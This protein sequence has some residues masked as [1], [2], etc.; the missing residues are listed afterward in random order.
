[1]SY[2]TA[3]QTGTAAPFG[4]VSPA[5]LELQH[6]QQGGQIGHAPPTYGQDGGNGHPG[7]LAEKIQYPGAGQEYVSQPQPTLQPGAPQ[8]YPPQQQQQGQMYQS[9]T[10]LAS[11]QQGPTPV[12]CPSCG[13]R[14]LTRTEFVSGGTTHLAALLFCCVTC[15]GCIPYMA[16]WFKDVEH[17]CGNCGTLLAVWHKSGRT[18]VMAHG[19]AGAGAG[20]K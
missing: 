9:A 16:S 3:Q 6:H 15:L 5:P 1:M 18:E 10:P 2:Q 4:A 19:V 12:D 14:A 8:A 17:H 20:K 11:L 13:Q 7:E